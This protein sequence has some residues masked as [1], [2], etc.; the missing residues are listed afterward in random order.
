MTRFPSGLTRRSAI[1]LLVLLIAAI[2]G[3]VGLFLFP[4]SA[5]LLIGPVI[6]V[7][8]TVKRWYWLAAPIR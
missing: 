8:L 7:S 6:D 3:L 4:Q 5:K 1:A 2:A